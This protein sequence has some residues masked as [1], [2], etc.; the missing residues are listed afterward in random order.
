MNPET[1]IID[2]LSSAIGYLS[3]PDSQNYLRFDI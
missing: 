1:R 3:L 2:H